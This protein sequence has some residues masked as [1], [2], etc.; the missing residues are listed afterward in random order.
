MTLF[1]EMRCD[2]DRTPIGMSQYDESRC[3]SD[4]NAGPWLHSSET[5]ESIRLTL[6][7]LKQI[8]LNYGWVKR[9]RDWIC[10]CCA[11]RL[12]LSSKGHS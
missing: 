6:A 10:P 8:A 3:W 4:E 1:V 12:R 5:V 2:G 9:G 11:E 7:E